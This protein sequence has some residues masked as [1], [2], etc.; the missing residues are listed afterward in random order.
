MYPYAVA[1]TLNTDPIVD[2]F[3]PPDVWIVLS[4]VHA[5]S[6]VPDIVHTVDVTVCDVV[7]LQSV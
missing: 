1:L 7:E 5:V 2:T 4:G 6:V 3:A